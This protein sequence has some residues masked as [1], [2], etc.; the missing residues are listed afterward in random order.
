MSSRGWPTTSPVRRPAASSICCS[1]RRCNRNGPG[2][3]SIWRKC[4]LTPYMDPIGGPRMKRVL[5]AGVLGGLL[6][7]GTPTLASSAQR[8][9]T[10]A[11]KGHG[12]KGDNKG[13]DH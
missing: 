12:D 5:V 8:D 13:G 4:P 7:L 11:E 6:L 9:S 3:G 2:V 10:R 1:P